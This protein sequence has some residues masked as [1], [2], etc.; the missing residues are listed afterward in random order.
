MAVTVRGEPRSRRAK[1]SNRVDDILRFT[2]GS[3]FVDGRQCNQPA[4]VRQIPCQFHPCWPTYVCVQVSS[5]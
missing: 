1:S 3:R 5:L 4:G 2:S